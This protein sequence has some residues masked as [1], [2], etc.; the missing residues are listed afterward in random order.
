MN[1]LYVAIAVGLSAMIGP[2]LLASQL[3]RQRKA[4]AIEKAEDR[5]REDRVAA[6]AKRQQDEVAAEALRQQEEVAQ[7]AERAAALLLSAQ[8][9]T[10]ARTDEVAKQ[11]AGE[12][13]AA[14]QA[15]GVAVVI[16]YVESGQREEVL[17]S[18]VPRKGDRIRLRNGMSAPSVIVED[19]VWM[20][21]F[22]PP[23]NPSVIIVVR[24]QTPEERHEQT[25]QRRNRH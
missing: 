11:L 14:A 25:Q 1:A 3:N 15:Y 18:N 13:S 22:L 20:E 16:S 2:L 24:L 7:T 9:A 21:A 10:T 12:V 5:K 8:K 23:P 6:E 19:V 17:L 4:A